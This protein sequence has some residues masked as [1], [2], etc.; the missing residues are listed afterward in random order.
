[1]LKP[2]FA[3]TKNVFLQQQNEFVK[4]WAFKLVKVFRG[5]V[6]ICRQQGLKCLEKSLVITC[7]EFVHMDVC[8]A[9]KERKNEMVW[10][11]RM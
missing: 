9:V 6:I 4:V 7:I 8:Y 2:V 3:V 10:T 11:F 1:M 5:D